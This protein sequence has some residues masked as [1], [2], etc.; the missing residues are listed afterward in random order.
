MALGWLQPIH[1]Q[2]WRKGK[3]PYLEECIQVA[4]AKRSDAEACFQEWVMEKKL[5]SVLVT[6]KARMIGPQKALQFSQRGDDALEKLYQQ[7]YFSGTLSEKQ[8][9]KL[10]KKWE[11]EAARLLVTETD[12]GK[13]LA[14]FSKALK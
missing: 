6:Y 12:A 10:I 14:S 13:R 11:N 2:D 4:S 7:H 9:Q 1:F 3:I 5:K 8:Q